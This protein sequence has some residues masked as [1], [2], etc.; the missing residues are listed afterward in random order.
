MFSRSLMLAALLLGCSQ[1]KAGVLAQ[2]VFEFGTVEAELFD[3]DKPVTVRNFLD[4]QQSGVWSSTIMHRWVTNFVIQGGSYYQDPSFGPV[5]I[6]NRPAITNEFSVGPRLSNV[7]G[8]IAMARIGGQTNSATT[9]WFFNVK[10][11]AFLDDVDGGFTVFGRTLRGT[12]VL[13]RFKQPAGT[14]NLYFALD[15]T[16][17]NATEVPVY[18]TNSVG[19]YVFVDVKMLKAQIARVAGGNQISWNSIEGIPNAVDFSTNIPPVW[20]PITTNQGTGLTM[21]I[22]NDPGSDK[23]RH[24]RVRVIYPN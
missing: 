21:S 20:Q 5:V 24:Y 19:R 2:F 6:T 13:N 15:S 1:I 12:N 18:V 4:Y 16:G 23:L 14:T 3:V 17:T 22:T 9:S 8:T 7:Y 10:D 11:N